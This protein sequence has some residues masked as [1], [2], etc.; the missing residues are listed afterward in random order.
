[1]GIDDEYFD[2]MV[3]AREELLDALID[4]DEKSELL[5]NT[6]VQS[7]F[8]KNTNALAVHGRRHCYQ[9]EAAGE[10]AEAMISL[11][12]IGI[13]ATKGHLRTLMTRSSVF[14]KMVEKV[15]S[16]VSATQAPEV[17]E[18]LQNSKSAVA[19]VLTL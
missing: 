10:L 11:R 5:L 14:S 8:L 19:F 4:N 9:A 7:F 12:N 6:F 15:Q 18:G 16:L 1:M 13:E 2:E 17:S 3:G